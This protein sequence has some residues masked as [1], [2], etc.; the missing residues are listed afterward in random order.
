MAGQT[1]RGPGG[2]AFGLGMRIP[3]GPCVLVIGAS[4][5]FNLIAMTVAAENRRLSER[6]AVLTLLFDLCQLGAL[7]GADRRARQPVRAPD[8]G[9]GDDQRLG[10]EPARH[11]A[12]VAA[13]AVIITLLVAFYVPLELASGEALAL[14]EVLAIG[15]WA[16]LVTGTAFLAFYARRVTGETFSMSQALA[17]TQ[18]ALAREQ[19]LSALGGVVAAAAHELG[20]PLATI[21]LASTELIEE[22]ADRPHLQEDAQLVRAQADR[23]TGILRAM[24]PR[25]S[26]DALVRFA[27]FSSVV[28]EAAAPHAD[29]GVRIITRIEGASIEDGPE[30]QPQLAR[31]PEIIQG[32]RNLVQNAVDFAASTV[33]IDLDWSEAELTRGDRRRRSRLSSGPYRPDRRPVRPPPGAAAWRAAGLRGHGAR[34][35]HRQDAAR[36]QRRPAPFRQRRRRRRSYRRPAGIR[37]TERGGGDRRLVPGAGVDGCGFRRSAVRGLRPC[38]GSGALPS[39]SG[40]AKGTARAGAPAEEPGMDIRNIAIIAHVDHGKTTLV[41]ALLKQSGTFRENQATVERA[42]DSNDLERERGITILAKATSVDWQGHRINI[43]DTPGHADFGGEVERI[44]GMVDGVLL[45]V[46]A[47]EGPMPQTKFVHRQGA[48]PRPAPHRASS[49]RS[50]SPTPS[51][52]GR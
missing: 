6:E 17:A 46:D 29:R 13:A 33:W 20:T 28:E 47:A 41:D 14:P 10:A 15:S 8:H 42:L 11:H 12:L 3:H 35:V 1:A 50:T 5:A 49:T 7:S 39:R 34:A 52:T 36:A 23:C 45:L 9:A 26:E 27:P 4:A 21:K 44:L 19:Q 43:V 38:R 25:G 31:H 37:P 16:A 24:G 32:L 51:P 22:L 18:M 2:D 30:V 48:A 40:A